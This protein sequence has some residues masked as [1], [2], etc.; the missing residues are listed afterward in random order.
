MPRGSKRSY[1]SKRRG[2]HHMEE[3]AKKRGYTTKRAT[4]MS[5]G[6]MGKE[7][8]GKKTVRRKTRGTMAGRK[9][10]RMMGRGRKSR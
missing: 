2:A 6:T 8:A 9:G 5:Y 7:D 1:T 3:G 4:Q 10:S